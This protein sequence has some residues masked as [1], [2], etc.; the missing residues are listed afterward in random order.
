MSPPGN[1]LSLKKSAMPCLIPTAPSCT[2]ALVRP[3]AIVIMSGT[4]PQWLTANHSAGAAEP[5][6]HLVGNHEDAVLV[7]QCADAL[8]VAVRRNED[9][10]GAGD[11]FENERRDRLRPLELDD[12]LEIAQRFLGRIPPAFDAVIRVEHVHEARQRRLAP[13]P[14]LAG[15]GDRR[16]R[17]AVIRAIAG[18]DLLPAGER[19]RDLEGVFVGLGAA[20]RE[21]E[22]VD[23]ARRDLRRASR[24]AAPAARSPSPASRRSG[25][26]PVPESP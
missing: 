7:A 25:S 4:T 2:Y 1:G 9:P 22:D 23:I 3:L 21:E 15:R 13:A 20:V 24:R 16:G 11:R 12:F 14:R 18:Q 26:R 10:V 6:H 5:A 19:A 17:A 8:H